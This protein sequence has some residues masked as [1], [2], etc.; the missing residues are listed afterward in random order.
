MTDHMSR[1][2]VAAEAAGGGTPAAAAPG[3]GCP[4][5]SEGDPRADGAAGGGGPEAQRT[6]L[7]FCGGGDDDRAFPSNP[8]RFA[9][10]AVFYCAGKVADRIVSLYSRTFRLD[11]EYVA[12]Y[13]RSTGIAHV[14]RG[15]CGKAIPMLEK[16]IA[17]GSD[18]LETRMCLARAYSTSNM[19]EK[20]CAHLMEALKANPDSVRA[21]R[22]LGSL[23]SRR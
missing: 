3:D 18:D 21:L 16:A 7:Y 2:G 15:D 14:E 5:A 6:D 17:M 9:L 13:S 1:G 20:A 19:R 4:P 8:V 10:H 23:H 12:D 11:R 22:A